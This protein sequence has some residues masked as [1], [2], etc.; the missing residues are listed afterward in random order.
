VKNRDG[1][2]RMVSKQLYRDGM[3][4]LAAAVHI[5]TTDGPAGAAGF[6]AS[7]CCSVTDDPPT[8]LVCLNRFTQLHSIFQEN[9]VFC[10]NTLTGNQRELS[11]LFAHRTGMSMQERFAQPGWEKAA[12]G[13]PILHDALAVFDC[14]IS[15]VREV[16]THYVI[17][18]E[19]QGLR[20]ST[21]DSALLYLNR[22]YR[23]L[24][25]QKPE[26]D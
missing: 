19:V 12:S 1:A 14:R 9:G 21:G 3:S 2:I 22:S 24:P 26:D 17:F 11:E 7:A 20:L 6:T 18:G 16:G 23:N 13:S 25:L 10:V 15:E 5:I 4:R 8:L